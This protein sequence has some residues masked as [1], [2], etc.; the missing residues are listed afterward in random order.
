MQN[1]P[2]DGGTEHGGSS[3][4]LMDQTEAAGRPS[5]TSARIKA[6]ASLTGAT[7]STVNIGSGHT[8]TIGTAAGSTT[9]AGTITGAGNSF[10]IKDGASTEI[11]TGTNTYTGLTEVAAGVLQI[12]NGTTSGSIST[13]TPVVVDAAATQNIRLQANGGTFT[14]DVTNNGTVH[15]LIAGVGVTQ[16]LSGS[17]SGTGNLLADGSGVTI[18][19]RRRQHLSGRHARPAG[20]VV[21]IG[22]AAAA[23]TAGQ[24]IGTNTIVVDNGGII[25]MINV[26]GGTLANNI[27]NGIGGIGGV[28]MDSA[29]T[30]TLTGTITDGAAGSVIV[31]VESGGGTLILANS[32]NTY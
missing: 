31:N 7:T 15:S 9:F 18:T 8:L 13:S 14:N 26:S 25:D 20:S 3:A 24:N 11:F 1:A 23:S 17:I 28:Y 6:I 21:D 29:A 16:T 22:T 10:L 32:C 5:S 27:T 12:G 30:V 4:V 2:A 19:V